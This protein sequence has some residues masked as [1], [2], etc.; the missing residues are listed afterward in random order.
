MITVREKNEIIINLCQIQG[1]FK[2]GHLFYEIPGYFKVLERMC[3]I[4]GVFMGFFEVWEPC[5]WP[6]LAQFHDT[7]L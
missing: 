3:K 1:V 6:D 5:A 7:N 2:D 4:E